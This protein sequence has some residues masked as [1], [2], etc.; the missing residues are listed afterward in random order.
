MRHGFGVMYYY[1]GD[2]FE[3]EFKNNRQDGKGIMYYN[4]GE[5]KEGFWKGN[6]YLGN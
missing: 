3:G 4:N 1:N 6:E 5:I 2:R